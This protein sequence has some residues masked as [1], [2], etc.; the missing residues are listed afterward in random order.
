[1]RDTRNAAAHMNSSEETTFEQLMQ[2]LEKISR[3]L[4]DD[5]GS[6]EESLKLYERGVKIANECQSRLKN[7]E[8]KVE[9]L[10]NQLEKG[11][12][13]ANSTG[14]FRQEPVQSGPEGL[15]GQTSY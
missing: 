2:E 12:D 4:A 7:A 9:Y 3:Q 5:R 14:H 6:L 1:M 11:Q 8:Q 10:Q 15:S 13:D